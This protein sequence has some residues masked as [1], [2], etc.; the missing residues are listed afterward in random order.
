MLRHRLLL[1]ICAV[2]AVAYTGTAHAQGLAAE[3][4][5]GGNVLGNGDFHEWK[6]YAAG[7]TTESVGTPPNSLPTHWYG[8]PGVGAIATYDRIET[9]PQ[10]RERMG[11]GPWH[12]RVAWS[13]P[14]SDGWR[15]ETHHQPAFRFT[16]LECFEIGDVRKFAGKSVRV[17]F[18]GR[19]P[20]GKLELVPILWHSYDANTP[21]IQGIKGK[22]YELFESSG[23]TG[24][25]AV[26][27]GKP[28]AAAMCELG[29]SWAR[30]E[31]IIALPAV[32]G[33][34]ITPGHYTG[35]GFDLVARGAPTIALA[36]IEVRELVAR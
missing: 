26:A 17:S 33:K 21:G 35:V 25:V 19:S 32:E 4:V 24:K 36:N 1:G 34:S 5:A 22:G 10:D 12:F 8:G 3:E 6:N 30:I 2:S 28:D 14:Q 23:Q 20:T 9:S 13:K 11:I 31:K 27:Q 7:V 15:G 16:F 18:F 29:P